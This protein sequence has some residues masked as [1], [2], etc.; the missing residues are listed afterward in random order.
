MSCLPEQA[1]TPIEFLRMSSGGD[2]VYA[3]IVVTGLGGVA[4]TLLL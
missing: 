4:M 2:P 3:G 1:E